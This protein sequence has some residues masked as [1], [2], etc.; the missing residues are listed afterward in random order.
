MI[1]QR[2][3]LCI[4]IGLILGV[5]SCGKTEDSQADVKQ[6]A[7]QEL[8]E[9][10][11][12]IL[13]ADQIAQL[14][15]LDAALLWTK[16]DSAKQMVDSA[17]AADDLNTL[18]DALHKAAICAM[19]LRRADIAAWQLNNIGYY[20]IEE[21][22]KRTNY[23]TRMRYIERMPQ[24]SSK[25]RYIEETRLILRSEMALLRNASRYLEKAYD[26]DSNLDDPER[27]QKIYSNLK[28][29]DWVRNFIEKR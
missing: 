5:S 19:A 2:Q 8:A 6:D 21:F 26:L 23:H 29:I 7:K 9:Q 13:P 11:L 14:Q 10:E 1:Y 4:T 16:Y 28:Y 17:V 22:Q 24:D 27:T 20:S 15:Q 18:M 3:I 25:F 12:I